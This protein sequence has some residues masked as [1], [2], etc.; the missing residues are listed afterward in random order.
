MPLR[1]LL[2]RSIAR[3]SGTSVAAAA[4]WIAAAASFM[5]PATRGE[6]AV[7]SRLTWPALAALLAGLGLVAAMAAGSIPPAIRRRLPGLLVVLSAP[8][9]VLL[10]GSGGMRSPAL[11]VAG[12]LLM[13][14]TATLGYRAGAI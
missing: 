3:H 13:G 11:A 9:F 5:H 8:A 6:L 12:L 4:L 10:A 14:V 7:G 1:A 2:I